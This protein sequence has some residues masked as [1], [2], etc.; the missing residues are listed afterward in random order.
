MVVN[1]LVGKTLVNRLVEILDLEGL[2]S[3]R[4]PVEGPNHCKHFVS[5]VF[6]LRIFYFAI[7]L[8]LVCIL[9]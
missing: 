8:A 4:R 2:G 7:L 1:P 6:R 9:V 5:I 3:R